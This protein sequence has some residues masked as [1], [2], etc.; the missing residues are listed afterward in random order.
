MHHVLFV[1]VGL[2][3]T[4]VLPCLGVCLDDAAVVAAD[5]VAVVLDGGGVAVRGDTPPVRGRRGRRSGA[6]AHRLV[7]VHRARLAP[8]QQEGADPR[9]DLRHAL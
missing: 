9:V 1:L 3:C 2:C 8:E 5:V 7:T 6:G 4:A